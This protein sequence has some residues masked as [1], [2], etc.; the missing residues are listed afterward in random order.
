MPGFF[1]TMPAGDTLIPHLFRTEYR[2]IVAVLCKTFGIE[3]IET[4]EDI[5][6]ETFL[7]AA[8]TWGI[9]GLPQNP[10]AW[11][12]A[13][14]KNKTKDYLKRHVIFQQKIV[15]ELKSRGQTAYEPD[16]DLSGKNIGDSQLQMIFAVCHPVIKAEAQIGLALSILCGFG[17]EE[18]A[19][20]FLSNKETIYK[21]LARAKEKL[22]EAGVQIAMPASGELS[23]RL[24]AVL[25]TLYLLF[26]EGYYSQSKNTPLRKDLCLEAMRL[27]YLLLEYELTNTPAVRALLALMCFHASRFDARTD[28]NGERVLYE[29]QDTSLWNHELI[30]RGRYYLNAA[31]TGTEISKYHIE[32]AIAELH[33]EKTD[34]PAKWEQVL[35]LYNKLLLIEYSPMAALNRT[36]AFSK[37]RT[38]VGAIEEAEKLGLVGHQPYHFLLGYL[39]RYVNINTGLQ[40]LETALALARTE[41]DKMA[42]RKA[43]TKFKNKNTG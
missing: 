14:A 43:I 39:Y 19:D 10:V 42:V 15:A 32:A 22:R 35:Q 23:S 21:R 9:N 36:Y 37:A 38:D 40:H 20:A 3:H 2:K 12:Y 8:E 33:S 25:T 31:A 30:A 24:D 6:S 7:L 4:A 13:V 18:I 41:A 26:N 5:A 28:G 34:T 17:A 27:N 1:I 11:L 16:I 29:D